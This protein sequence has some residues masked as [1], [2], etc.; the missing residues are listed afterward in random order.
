MPSPHRRIGLVVDQPL[1]DALTLLKSR[2]PAGATATIAREAVLDAAALEALQALAAGGDAAGRR[3][4][5]VLRDLRDALDSVDVPDAVSAHLAEALDA[6]I[7]EAED[8]GR[9]DLQLQLLEAPNPHGAAALD[10]VDEFDELET[11]H[12]A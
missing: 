11:N 3:A 5:L 1:E 12:P 6:A 10:L 7:T 4:V 2:R 9:R 8:E